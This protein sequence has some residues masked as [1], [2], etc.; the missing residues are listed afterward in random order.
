MVD[1]IAEGFVLT[2]ISCENRAFVLYQ[3]DCISSWQGAGRFSKLTEDMV[4]LFNSRQQ[5]PD[6]MAQKIALWTEIYKAVR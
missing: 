1:F 3:R 2:S 4:T 5:L 6:T